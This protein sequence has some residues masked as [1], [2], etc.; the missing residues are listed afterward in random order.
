MTIPRLKTQVTALIS[1]KAHLE[2]TREAQ[3]RPW[4]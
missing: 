3:M 1:V 4:A 2:G